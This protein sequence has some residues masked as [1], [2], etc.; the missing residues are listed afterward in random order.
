MPRADGVAYAGLV[1]NRRGLDRALAAGVDE[2]NMVVCVSETFNRRNQNATTAES[3]QAAGRGAGRARDDGLFTTLTLAT[4]FGCPFEGEVDPERVVELAARGG[5]GRARRARAGRHHRGR[6]AAQVRDLAAGSRAVGG[7]R[8]CASTST[9]PAT[10]ASPT[11][12]PPSSWASTVLDASAG[13]IGGCPFAP[14]ATGNIATDDLVYLLERMGLDTGYD[15]EA[16]LPT[17]AFLGDQLGHEVPALLPRAGVFPQLRGALGR[18]QPFRLRTAKS[19]SK[20]IRSTRPPSPRGRPTSERPVVHA[21]WLSPAVNDVLPG[22]DHAVDRVEGWFRQYAATRDPG[23]REQIIVAYL[24]LADRLAERYRGSRGASPR[25]SARR[26]GSG[27][28]RPSTATTPTTATRSS[29]TPWPVW[30]AR[31]SATCA[32]PAGGSTSRGR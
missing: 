6:R 31:S 17:A 10:P 8:R 2:V 16:L 32:T 26:P 22:D 21:T 11:P 20:W 4:S 3:M 14:R 29:P 25:T 9:T 27:W 19:G 7:R 28:W 18:P 30:S 13:G 24:G 23:I 1:L 12:S 15:L 5:R